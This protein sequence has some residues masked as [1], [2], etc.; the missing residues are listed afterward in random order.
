MDSH[1]IQ[2]CQQSNFDSIKEVNFNVCN[3]INHYKKYTDDI[4]NDLE[5]L[6]NN[7]ENEVE[8]LPYNVD[9]LYN[10]RQELRNYIEDQEDTYYYFQELEEAESKIKELESVIE[11]LHKKYNSKALPI[12]LYL[13]LQAL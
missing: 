3:L 5:D 10:G 7:I 4:S 8:I 11:K 9:E 6:L 12:D 2:F 13:E 1:T